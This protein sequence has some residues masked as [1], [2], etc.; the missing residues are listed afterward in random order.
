MKNE[1]YANIAAEF[2]D[3]CFNHW[4]AFNNINEDKESFI[5]AERVKWEEKIG[6]EPIMEPENLALEKSSATKVGANII[7]YPPMC[8]LN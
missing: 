3:D 1:A 4:F 2:D 5:D 7:F 6:D 8:G